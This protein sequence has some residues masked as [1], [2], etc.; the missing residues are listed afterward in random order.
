MVSDRCCQAGLGVCGEMVE[1][2]DVGVLVSWGPGFWWGAGG[3]GVGGGG[4]DVAAG[5]GGSDV[6]AGGGSSVV[7]VIERARGG[8]WTSGSSRSGGVECFGARPEFSPATALVA[9]LF[10]RWREG[11]ERI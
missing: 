9:G 3:W 4:S 11:R 6:A 2:R 1:V 5:G 7:L 10:F 8:A